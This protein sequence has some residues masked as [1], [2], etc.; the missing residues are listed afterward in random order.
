MIWI[1]SPR[2]ERISDRKGDGKA[3]FPA[4]DP[5]FGGKGART[6]RYRY[7]GQAFWIDDRDLASKR[8]FTFLRMFSSIAETGVAPQAPVLT[9]PPN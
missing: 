6:A 3:R 2:R 9:I 8:M 4:P 1:K 7:R 5:G